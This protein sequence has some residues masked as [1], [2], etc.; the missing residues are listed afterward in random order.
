MS[1]R[2]INRHRRALQPKAAAGSDSFVTDR[3]DE[4]EEMDTKDVRLARRKSAEDAPLVPPAGDGVNI[5]PFKDWS[6]D[7]LDSTIAAIAKYPED[8]AAMRALEQM[9]QEARLRPAPPAEQP[10][11]PVTAGRKA[12]AGA[13]ATNQDTLDVIEGTNVDEVAQAH[14]L[15]D[16]NTGIERPKTVLPEKFAGEVSAA[17]A[18]KLAEEM[19]DKLQALYMDAKVLT[20]VNSTRPVREAVESI[21]AAHVAFGEAAKVLNK[22]LIAD[23]ATEDAAKAVEEKGKKK[24]SRSLIANLN[25]AQPEAE[26]K[27]SSGRKDRAE[28]IHVLETHSPKTQS[29]EINTHS[30]RSLGEEIMR[31]SATYVRIQDSLATSDPAD[32]TTEAR[33]QKERAKEVEL[34]DKIT[35]IA[36]QLGVT[37]V[38][39]SDPRLRTVKIQTPDGFTN[40]ETGE[41]INVPTS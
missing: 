5:N 24:S 2:M 40:D 3:D 15:Q 30:T 38:F 27:T 29:G 10:A 19:A 31:L 14:G 41:G 1:S 33:I 25:I 11:A 17:K 18:V 13:P 28:F 23:E 9:V 12:A 22:Q 32:P 16:D 21:Y 4:M 36:T 34:K 6:K 26:V 39:Q 37:A 7:A 35:A 8:K 20:N